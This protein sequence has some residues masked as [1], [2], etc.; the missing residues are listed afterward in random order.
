MDSS[1]FVG[2][3]LTV[4]RARETYSTGREVK[5]ALLI[6]IG[7]LLWLARAVINALRARDRYGTWSV[8]D[9]SIDQWAY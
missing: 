6:R 8:S 7:E 5:Q 9:L 1:D 4:D 3:L 2:K